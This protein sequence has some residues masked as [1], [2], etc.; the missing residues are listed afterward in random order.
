MSNNKFIT[1]PQAIE[2]I[3]KVKS[4]QIWIPVKAWITKYK[5]F[6]IGALVLIV[7]IGS[8]AVGKRLSQK[9]TPVYIPPLIEVVTTQREAQRTSAFSALKRNILELN[10]Q[11]PDPAIPSFDN[12]LNLE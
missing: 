11:L 9:S 12:N 1:N 4:G 10:L 2:F 8:V 7:L 6:L 3:N 5:W